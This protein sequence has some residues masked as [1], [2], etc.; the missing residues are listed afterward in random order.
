[1]NAPGRRRALR[2]LGALA[3][4]P[5]A[6]SCRPRL[7]ADAV[8]VPLGRLAE[9]RRVTVQWRGEPVELRQSAAGPVARSLLCTHWGC[10][11]QWDEARRRY[12]C[13]CHGGEFDDEGRPVA[14]PPN[15]PLAS[16]PVEVVG[17]EAV[18][19]LR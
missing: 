12:L 2:A 14:G 7:P 6:S 13:P 16:V 1:M 3:L 17:D 18:L 9:G 8:R 4:L 5:A 19:G 11:L 10:P 15:R